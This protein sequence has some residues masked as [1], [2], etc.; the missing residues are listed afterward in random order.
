M[1]DIYLL[2][3]VQNVWAFCLLLPP[4]AVVRWGK[5][6]ENRLCVESWWYLPCGFCVSQ[7]VLQYNHIYLSSNLLYCTMCPRSSGPFYTVTYYIK[8]VT[9]SLAHSIYLSFYILYPILHNFITAQQA[10]RHSSAYAPLSLFSLAIDNVSKSKHTRYL[11]Q[12][13]AI[14]LTLIVLG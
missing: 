5:R 3:I 9:T 8:W 10:Q 1:A 12:G 7:A 14:Y 13:I 2:L 6:K 4:L 11:K